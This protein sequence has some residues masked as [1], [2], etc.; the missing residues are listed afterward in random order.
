M[1]HKTANIRT[2]SV[3]WMF[4]WAAAATV[5]AAGTCNSCPKIYHFFASICYGNKVGVCLRTQIKANKQFIGNMLELEFVSERISEYKYIFQH[6]RT[7]IRKLPFK[8]RLRGTSAQK[9]CRHLNFAACFEVRR[10]SVL[11]FEISLKFNLSL[12]FISFKT[13]FISFKCTHW[14]RFGMVACAQMKSDNLQIWNLLIFH[15]YTQKIYAARLNIVNFVGVLEKNCHREPLILWV[16]WV[17][18]WPF[19]VLDIFQIFLFCY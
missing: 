19:L 8:F 6:T 16:H 17:R 9:F 14:W 3:I 1:S 4:Y 5:P 15:I 2:R 13:F 12:F 11:P 10:I 7:Y 18:M